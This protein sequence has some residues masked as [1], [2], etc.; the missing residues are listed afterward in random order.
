MSRRCGLP[1]ALVA[2]AVAAGWLGGCGEQVDYK[3][4]EPQ[5]GSSGASSGGG[6]HEA[7]SCGDGELAPG[8]GC[9]DGAAQDGD[10]CS[11]TCQV[12]AGWTCSGEP[13]Q[14]ERLCGNGSIDA[15]EDCDGQELG[16]KDCTGVPGGF[17][18]GKL[19]CK[20]C[21]FDTT[22]CTLA[23]CG[24]GKLDAGEACDDGNKSDEDECLMSCKKASCGDAHLG[25]GHE[26]C[27]DG[28]LEPGDGC[29]AQCAKEA[30]QTV[31]FISTVQNGWSSFPIFYAGNVH[32][33]QAPIV[34][35][36]AVEA[37]G[38]I[39][40]FALPSLP[41]YPD[42]SYHIMDVGTIKWTAHASIPSAFGA[43]PIDTV[44][45][46]WEGPEPDKTQISLLAGDWVYS[47]WVDNKTGTIT[48]A[49]Q[50]PSQHGWGDG[51]NDPKTGQTTAAWA[52]TDNNQGWAPSS[53]CNNESHA[54]KAWGAALSQGGTLHLYDLT[55]C[56]M[57][58]QKLPA[59]SF[60]PFT[61]NAAPPLG[62]IGAAAYVGGGLV[63]VTQP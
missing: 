31:H 35:A 53:T 24:D 13:S 57:F 37:R 17:A 18:G 38:E 33:P 30:L 11:A 22:N 54:V 62:K 52:A 45:A 28:N 27:D 12:E 21:A 48:P 39:Y 7:G 29:S 40:A 43:L 26:Q 49:E 14:C 2:V 60:A 25:E 44:E 6:G 47:F 50:S 56:F 9:D 61:A 15:G 3:M 63:V 41:A 23:S 55:S 32:A 5:T 10:G 4:G 19:G 46:A 42:G 20:A 58:Y 34:A 51:P 1:W 8:E 16:G 59:S 36:A